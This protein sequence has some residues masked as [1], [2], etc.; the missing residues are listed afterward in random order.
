MVTKPEFDKWTYSLR[1]ISQNTKR[2]WNP[3]ESWRAKSA[4]HVFLSL[5]EE[6]PPK[7]FVFE[8]RSGAAEQVIFSFVLHPSCFEIVKACTVKKVTVGCE[9]L[10]NVPYASH[11]S[12][13]TK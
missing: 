12:E 7:K 5:R 1:A 3:R 13:D 8:P 2:I 11:S 6:T 10:K 9:T 4:G